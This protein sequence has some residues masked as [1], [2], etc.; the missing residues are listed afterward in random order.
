M[1]GNWLLWQEHESDGKTN[2]FI[3]C[4]YIFRVVVIV[5]GVVVVAV[6]VVAAAAFAMVAAVAVWRWWRRRRRR[7]LPL[8]LLLIWLVVVHMY[9]NC[10]IRCVFAFILAHVKNISTHLRM[11]VCVC[12]CWLFCSCC[13]CLSHFYTYSHTQYPKI[14]INL[15][16]IEEVWGCLLD[17]QTCQKVCPYSLIPQFDGAHV[18]ICQLALWDWAIH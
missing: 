8:L 10:W 1:I 5:I 13:H 6:A 16:L 15:S 3:F 14:L 12:V 18:R 7:R 2:L 11:S 4:I 17:S 9:E